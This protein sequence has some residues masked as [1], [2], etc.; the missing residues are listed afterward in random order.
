LRLLLG[1]LGALL[2]RA[3]KALQGRMGNIDSKSLLLRNERHR[4]MES[5]IGY[6]PRALG[7]SLSDEVRGKAQKQRENFSCFSLLAET[8]SATLKNGFKS[9]R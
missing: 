5:S 2:F 8:F 4:L 6:G 3:K 9:Q 1:N 7:L